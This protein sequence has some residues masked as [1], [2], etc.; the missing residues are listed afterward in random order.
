MKV[1]KKN[2]GIIHMLLSSTGL[3]AQKKNLVYGFT[4]GREESSGEMLD[5]EAEEMIKYLRQQEKALND[6]SEDANKMR[7]KILSMCHRLQWT[8]NGRV[9]MVRLENWCKEKSYLKKGLNEY[10]Y[11]ELPKLVS[12]FKN[13][14]M[15]VIKRVS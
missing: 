6:K 4:D 3:A 7:R 11:Q 14:Y 10:T 9:D 13:V 15:S 2:L 1:T 5:S 8:V 12:Q